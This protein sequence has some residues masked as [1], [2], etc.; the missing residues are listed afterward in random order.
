MVSVPLRRDEAARDMHVTSMSPYS[1]TVRR[2]ETNADTEGNLSRP[3][4]EV[5]DEGGLIRYLQRMGPTWECVD[6][7]T[8][9]DRNFGDRIEILT[10]AEADA[11]RDPCA[12]VFAIRRF[13]S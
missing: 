2:G 13:S 10:R 3:R 5:W 11:T 6:S 4:G 8:I 12:V 7:P 9:I 1:I